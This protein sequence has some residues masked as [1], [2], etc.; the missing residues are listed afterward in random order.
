MHG[1][2]IEKAFASMQVR[3]CGEDGLYCPHKRL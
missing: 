2:E 3:N 1:L